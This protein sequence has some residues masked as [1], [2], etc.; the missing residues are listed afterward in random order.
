MILQLNFSVA[1]NLCWNKEAFAL[2]SCSGFFV[3]LVVFA[4][5]Q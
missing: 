5:V 3:V 1:L 2:G 4:F